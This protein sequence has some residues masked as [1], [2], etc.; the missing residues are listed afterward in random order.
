MNGFFTILCPHDLGNC[1][2]D[3]SI[4]SWSHNE[5]FSILSFT[6]LHKA[7]FHAFLKSISH[8]LLKLIEPLLNKSSCLDI[9]EERNLFTFIGIHTFDNLRVNNINLDKVIEACLQM[10]L[11]D[12]NVLGVGQDINKLVIGQEIESWECL[13]LQC[14]VVIKRF[15]DFVKSCVILGKIIESSEWN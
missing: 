6:D 10:T 12:V 13:S 3:L 7:I 5:L 11:D 4:I 8:L 1:S 9:L 15:L 2:N 14:H